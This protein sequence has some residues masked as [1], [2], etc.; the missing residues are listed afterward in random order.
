MPTF[1]SDKEGLVLGA[2]F[3]VSKAR[4]WEWGGVSPVSSRLWGHHKLPQQ[5]P[6]QIHV[7]GHFELQRLHLVIKNVPFLM[8]LQKR[9]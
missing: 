7:L 3:E 1:H 6:G 8:I 4:G 2:E 9:D 5:G